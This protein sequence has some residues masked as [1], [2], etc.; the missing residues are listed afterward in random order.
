MSAVEQTLPQFSEARLGEINTLV[1]RYP[2][3]RS[4]LLPVLHMAQE[5]FGISLWMCRRW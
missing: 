5:D 3:A 2:H 1:A 4:A